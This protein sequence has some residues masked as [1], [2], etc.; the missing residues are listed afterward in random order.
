MGKSTIPV[1]NPVTHAA[2]RREVLWQITIPLILGVL[3]LLAL[4]VLTVIVA[5]QGNS[6]A[7]M[8]WGDISAMWLILPTVFF[9]LILTALFAGLLYLVI[10]LVNVVPGYARRIQDI[11]AKVETKVR[12]ISNKAASP[13]IKVSE[14]A[15]A[16]QAA[17]GNN[18]SRKR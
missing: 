5:I 1:R 11:F 18:P 12:S 7:V 13:V 17:L 14:A 4:A 9:I 10:R 15:A 16:V 6:S 3:I 8:V 2:H